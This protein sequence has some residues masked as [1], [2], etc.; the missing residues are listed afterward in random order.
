MNILISQNCQLV[1]LEFLCATSQLNIF[2]GNC[3]LGGPDLPF[4]ESSVLNAI[5]SIS[6]DYTLGIHLGLDCATLNEIKKY[7]VNEQKQ[8]LVARWFAVE[9]PKNCNWTKLNAAINKMGVPE[10]NDRNIFTSTAS[11]ESNASLLT[12]TSK[13]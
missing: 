12:T 7:P 6:D 8:K 2:K 9:E 4:N 13:L 1:L 3:F 10:W 5:A 11:L